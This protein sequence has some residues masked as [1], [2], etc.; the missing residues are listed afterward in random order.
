MPAAY[1][2][3]V[4]DP[5]VNS[6]LNPKTRVASF[7]H[8]EGAARFVAIKNELATDPGDG[9]MVWTFR[10]HRLLFTEGMKHGA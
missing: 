2:S 4:F 7:T 10:R 5:A 1:D 8:L 9:F 3:D 6:N